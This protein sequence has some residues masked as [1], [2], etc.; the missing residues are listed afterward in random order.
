VRL[1]TKQQRELEILR[2][3]TDYSKDIT[4]E[5]IKRYFDASDRGIGAKDA[6]LALLNPSKYPAGFSKLIAAKSR[7]D[8]QIE[9]WKE[10]WGSTVNAWSFTDEPQVIAEW[11][12]EVLD[13]EAIIM[14]WHRA[15]MNRQ[16]RLVYKYQRIIDNKPFNKSMEV[17]RS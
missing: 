11:V 7:R 15:E 17:T 16:R 4:D 13:R 8:L 2:W 1:S 3:F 12:A 10:D 14:E 6:K 9:S 5:D